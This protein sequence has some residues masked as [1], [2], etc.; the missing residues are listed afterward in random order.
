MAQATGS[1]LPPAT[2]TRVTT[3][4]VPHDWGWRGCSVH[5]CTTCFN[6][7]MD[8]LHE[9]E[10]EVLLQDKIYHGPAKLQGHQMP[11]HCSEPSVHCSRASPPGLSHRLTHKNDNHHTGLKSHAPK[12]RVKSSQG[13]VNLPKAVVFDA[14]GCITQGRTVSPPCT[15]AAA[16]QR[17][18]TLAVHLPDWL[19]YCQ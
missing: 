12:A 11:A 18:C 7:N 6:S 14:T 17:V 9:Q 10:T 13:G 8:I 15:A 4:L 3:G 19:S 5:G 16:T 1:I 2:L